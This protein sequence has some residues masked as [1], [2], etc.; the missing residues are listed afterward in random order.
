MNANSREALKKF[1]TVA[2][3]VILRIGKEPMTSRERELI[4]CAEALKS[5]LDRDETILD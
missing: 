3:D 2:T 5:Q 4:H 1:V